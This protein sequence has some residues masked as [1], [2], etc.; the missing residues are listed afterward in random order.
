MNKSRHPQTSACSFT[1]I[2]LLVVISIIAILAALLLP[3]LSRA[4]M[5]AQAA[6]CLNNMRQISLAGRLYAADYNGFVP[7]EYTPESAVVMR[8]EQFTGLV[9]EVCAD[10]LLTGKYP[11]LPK[12]LDP[13][14]NGTLDN[15]NR[16]YRDRLLAALFQKMPVIQC[17]SFP[18]I[19]KSKYF[20]TKHPITGEAITIREQTYD[21]VVNGWEF[22]EVK[23]GKFG[24]TNTSMAFFQADFVGAT[25]LTKIPDPMSTVYLTEADRTRPIMQFDLHDIWAAKHLWNG[26]SPRVCSDRNRHLTKVNANFFDGH[27]EAREF[28]QFNQEDFTDL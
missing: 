5:Y 20:D 25:N 19:D 26:P 6:V 17:P 28:Y 1:L 13:A 21:Y 12:A 7:R 4:K 3:V 9:P 14:A 27:A 24:D 15:S 16:T 10:Y 22:K 2:E 23:G 18:A 8:G 11:L